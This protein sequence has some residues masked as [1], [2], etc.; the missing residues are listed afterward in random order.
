[1]QVTSGGRFQPNR[2]SLKLRAA[3]NERYGQ[4]AFPENFS[5]AVNVLQKE[6][7]CL[8][9]LL[10]S[11]RNLLPFFWK[12]KVRQQI[13]EPGI[14]PVSLKASKGDAELPQTGMETLFQL[15]EIGWGVAL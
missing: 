5:F 13:R 2:A 12:K 1:M 4:D 15:V 10:K 3:K 7:E 11:A 6:L 14:C 8:Y 9:P